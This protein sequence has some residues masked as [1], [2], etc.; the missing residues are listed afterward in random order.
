[1]AIYIILII[2]GL[3]P[4]PPLKTLPL[5]LLLIFTLVWLFWGEFRTKMIKV[6]IDGDI[7]SVRQFGG[8]GKKRD[9]LFSEVDG[10]K[11]SRQQY[12]AR[13]V[14]E[15]LYLMKGKRKTIKL[16]EAYHKNYQDLKS[17]VKMK[18]KDLGY[19]NFN[20]IDELREAFL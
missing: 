13:G 18:S 17:A 19:E 2:M 9:F 11:I 14:L 12:G 5:L 6:S 20:F 4:I 16:S 15:Y 7:I 3:V 8:L 10:F 1:M